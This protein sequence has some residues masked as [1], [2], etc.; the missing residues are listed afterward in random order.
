MTR[1]PVCLFIL[2]LTGFSE[3]RRKVEE[4]KASS[5]VKEVTILVGKAIAGTVETL[6]FTV[7]GKRDPAQAANSAVLDSHHSRIGRRGSSPRQ[8]ISMCQSDR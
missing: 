6:G 4:S 3:G 5:Q 7:I 2:L 1:S 8:S